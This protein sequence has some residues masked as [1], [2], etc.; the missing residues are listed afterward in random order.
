MNINALNQYI[1]GYILEIYRDFCILLE[2]EKKNEPI[3]FL[4]NFGNRYTKTCGIVNGKNW[5][6]RFERNGKLCVY[7]PVEIYRKEDIMKNIIH[8]LIHVC[9]ESQDIA[10][11]TNGK[12]H[13]KLFALKAQEFGIE[14]KYS[15]NYGW[16]FDT[17]PDSIREDGLRIIDRYYDDLISY[18]KL[19]IAME[20]ARNENLSPTSHNSYVTYECPVCK[21]RIKAS[22]DSKIICAVCE[23]LFERISGK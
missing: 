17:I 4:R 21:K 12:Y 22:R 2:R 23:R 10:E 18:T 1:L 5:A 3:F 11:S 9:N 19:Y 16:N 7:V 20:R 13:K 6:H 8:L 15:K 14:C